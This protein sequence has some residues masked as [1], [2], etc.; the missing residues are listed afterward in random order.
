MATP[1]NPDFGASFTLEVAEIVRQN[2][3][4]AMQMG[5]PID[6]ADRATFQWNILRT[7]DTAGGVAVDPAGRPYDFS[8]TPETVDEH[9]DVQIDVAYQFIE[10][11]PTGTAL[12]QMDNPRVE[13]TVLDVDYALVEGA[14]KVLLGGNQYEIDFWKVDG[15]F[16]LGV[17][18]CYAHATDET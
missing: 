6:P 13:I 11:Q 2:L 1:T 7:Y 16:S 12:G 14:S 4:S 18:T 3:K 17:W 9:P 10:H 15:L 8:V 5:A